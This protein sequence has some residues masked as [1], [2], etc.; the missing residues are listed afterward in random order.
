MRAGSPPASCRDVIAAPVPD[1]GPI[2]GATTTP[3]GRTDLPPPASS[4][5]QRPRWSPQPR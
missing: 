3:L 5:G 4:T 1:L 2:A